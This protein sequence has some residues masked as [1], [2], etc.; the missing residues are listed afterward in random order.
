MAKDT[1]LDELIDYKDSIVKRLAQ[2]Q[3]VVGLLLNDPNV[4]MESDAAYDIVGNNIYDFDYVDKTVERDDAY[5]M[6]DAEMVSPSSGSFN[7][8][9]LYVQIVCSKKYNRLDGKLFKGLK[10]NRRDNLA[11]QIDVLLN[12]ATGFGVGR[13]D[14]YSASP[15]QVPDTFTSILL[16]YDIQEFRHERFGDR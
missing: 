13:L 9:C 11:R 1:Y 12:G 7:K 15:A 8:W 14:L 4:D 3:D 2:S 16:T 5:I 10:G 6:V